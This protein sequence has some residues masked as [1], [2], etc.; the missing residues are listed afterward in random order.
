MYP[1]TKIKKI[2]MECEKTW[3]GIFV[4]EQKLKLLG[5]DRRTH[6]ERHKDE[7]Y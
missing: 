4:A 1:P 6:P 2:G 3:I 7:V 5:L